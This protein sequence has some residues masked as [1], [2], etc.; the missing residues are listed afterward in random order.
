MMA[1]KAVCLA[2]EIIS[3]LNSY[4]LMTVKTNLVNINNLVK[5]GL[6]HI[7]VVNCLLDRKGKH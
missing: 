4:F 1:E 6:T 2:F 7:V 3:K 5:A